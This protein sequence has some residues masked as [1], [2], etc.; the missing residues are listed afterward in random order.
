[1]AMLL[2]FLWRAM[3]ICFSKQDSLQNSILV[4]PPLQEPTEHFHFVSSGEMSFLQVEHRISERGFG[5][6]L[7]GMACRCLEYGIHPMA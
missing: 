6:A 4:F 3:G 7:G 1:M 5:L 2:A